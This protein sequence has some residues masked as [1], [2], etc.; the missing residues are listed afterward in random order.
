MVVK[1]IWGPIKNVVISQLEQSVLY[2]NNLCFFPL[3]AQCARAANSRL[4]S[5]V[6]SLVTGWV[7]LWNLGD[8]PF[9]GTLMSDLMLSPI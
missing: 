3:G 9:Q 8:S 5:S 2:F 1:S 7:A 4:L 6:C